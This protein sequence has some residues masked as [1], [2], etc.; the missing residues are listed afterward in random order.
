MRP[1]RRRSVGHGTSLLVTMIRRRAV[2][3]FLS[4]EASRSQPFRDYQFTVVIIRRDRR[5]KYI[6][7]RLVPGEDISV[8]SIPGS[9]LRLRQRFQNVVRSPAARRHRI[10]AAQHTR[11]GQLADEQIS[12]QECKFGVFFSAVAFG[13]IRRHCSLNV[14]LGVACAYR[15]VLGV[16][17]K[18]QRPL[19][20]SPMFYRFCKTLFNFTL[21]SHTTPLIPN[22][23]LTDAITNFHL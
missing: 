7:Q 9:G 8:K 12:L 23:F 3:W 1:R 6:Q 18:W 5:K 2:M 19:T 21:S 4:A 17:M 20:A 13:V 11:S 16:Y 10:R 14:V 22:I 15:T